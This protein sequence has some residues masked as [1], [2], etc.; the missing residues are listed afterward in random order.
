LQIREVENRVWHAGST[1]IAPKRP[2]L[3]T[4]R[5]FLVLL[6]FAVSS[7]LGAPPA[8]PQLKA[9]V[10]R[11]V[12]LEKR[13]AASLLA[14]VV[15]N[16]PVQSYGIF[17]FRHSLQE[18]VT[19]GGYDGPKGTKFNPTF[20]GYELLKAGGWEALPIWYCGTGARA[21]NLRPGVNY[22]FRILLAY[23]ELSKAKQVRVLL[24]SG[25]GFFRSEPFT[26][27]K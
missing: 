6:L 21:F 24:Y 9:D 8:L 7:S 10:F 4:A 14:G 26:L 17:T 12:R 16:A 13:S 15:S 22:E 18:P 25:H 20:P 27:A 11:F 2:H 1:S 23:P 19:M 5:L 3:M